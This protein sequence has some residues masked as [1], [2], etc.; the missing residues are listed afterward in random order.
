MT[1]ENGELWLCRFLVLL[2]SQREGMAMWDEREV[3]AVV[4]RRRL[5]RQREE[6]AAW[7]DGACV[8]V[9]WV[10]VVVLCASV[11]GGLVVRLLGGV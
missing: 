10:C 6:S 4:R 7:V 8:G 11:V 9:M 2:W 5:E 1:P 3:S